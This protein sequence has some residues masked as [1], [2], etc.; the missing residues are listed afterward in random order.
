MM[1]ETRST[2]SGI[3]ALVG[4]WVLVSA[5]VFGSVGAVFWNEIVVGAAIALLAGYAAWKQESAS[6]V[7]WSA[8]LAAILGAWMIV[9]PFA[10]Q[11]T[12][13]TQMW[14]AVASGLIVLVF[15][16]YAAYDARSSEDEAATRRETAQ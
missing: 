1:A 16:G 5:F 4:L 9:A 14:S 7:T 10:F 11:M 3:S 12:V 13:G 8:S 6:A 15:A 2:L